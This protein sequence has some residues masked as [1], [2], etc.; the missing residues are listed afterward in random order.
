MTLAPEAFCYQGLIVFLGFL[1]ITLVKEASSRVMTIRRSTLRVLVWLLCVVAWARVVPA[2]AG[3]PRRDTSVGFS[4]GMALLDKDDQDLR[5]YKV[6][7]RQDLPW[8]WAL[9]RGFMLRTTVV[10]SAGM[11]VDSGDDAML[12]SA[13]PGLLLDRVGGR[14][15]T[16]LAGE[17]TYLSEDHLAGLDLGGQLQFTCHLGLMW[18]A[19]EHVALGCRYEH[20]SNADTDT[21]NP[22]LDMVS[23]DLIY[24]F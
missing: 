1:V 22:G 18:Y 24:T 9:G 19:F 10:A 14:W 17:L 15:A 2:W 23:L 16:D 12:V 5:T 7:L 21:T 4:G 13:G 11:L 6:F 20:I 3:E 8:P